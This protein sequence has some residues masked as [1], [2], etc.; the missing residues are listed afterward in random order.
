MSTTADTFRPCGY[1]NVIASLS[2]E[3]AT[4][5]M[6][7]YK[8][9]FNAEIRSSHMD[10]TGNKLMHGEIKIGD[11]IVFVSD[12]F[13]DWG[14][15]LSHSSFYLYVPDVDASYKQAISCGAK[16]KYE[17]KDQFWGDR[18]A[19]ITDP[20]GQRWTIATHLKE[21]TGAQLQEAQQEFMKNAKPGNM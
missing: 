8:Q 15:S 14:G 12:I 20:Y 10:P 19:D 21:V 4:K 18:T 16:S 3:N 17:P 5:G 11:S 13:A 6:E 9:A 1:S 7:W 2:I